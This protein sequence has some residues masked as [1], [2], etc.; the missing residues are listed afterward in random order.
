MSLSVDT[1]QHLKNIGLLEDYSNDTGRELQWVT[2][3]A[4]L[5]VQN[6]MGNLCDSIHDRYIICVVILTQWV[7]TVRHNFWALRAR[8]LSVCL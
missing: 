4:T 2:C 8:P 1:P 6:S 3:A 5:L 7:F